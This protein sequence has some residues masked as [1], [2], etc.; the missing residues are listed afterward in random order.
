MISSR[1]IVKKFEYKTD[2]CCEKQM[3][4]VHLDHLKDIKIIGIYK[5]KS[6]AEDVVKSLNLINTTECVI[7]EIAWEE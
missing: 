5:N 2:E 4:F 1:Y 7:E 3:V 6:T